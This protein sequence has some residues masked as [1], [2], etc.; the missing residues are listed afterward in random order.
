MD[1]QIVNIFQRLLETNNTA[2]FTAKFTGKNIEVLPFTF[3]IDKFIK[4]NGL[5]DENLKFRRI[6]NTLD[7][8][9]QNLFIEDQDENDDLT[10]ELLKTWLI[11]KFPPPPMK[12]EWLYKMKSIK[13]RKNEDP[14][15]VYDKFQ[16]ILSRVDAAIDLVNTNR[17]RR[18]RVRGITN[19]QIIDA[20]V[21]IFIRN[22]NQSNLDNNGVI[23]AKV[24]SFISKKNPSNIDDWETLFN[25]MQTELIPNCFKTLKEWQFI[26]YPTNI[27]DYDIYK[28]QSRRS[29]NENPNKKVKQESGKKRRRQQTLKAGYKKRK[30]NLYCQKCGRNNHHERECHASH[31][32]FGKLIRGNNPNN[33]SNNANNGR[34]NKG[35]KYCKR[36]RRNNHYTKDCHASFYPDNKPIN[37]NK[38]QKRGYH[39]DNNNNDH[40]DNN[41]NNRNRKEFHTR[42]P[43]GDM[44][45]KDLMALLTQKI[46]NNPNLNA[47]QQF[48]YMATLNN[49][50]NNMS[51]RQDK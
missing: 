6:F 15:L 39:N 10:V 51:A 49:L 45:T 22:N 3:E 43:N 44:S 19:E 42:K 7:V 2:Q 32:V 18:D 28:K 38:F 33:N 9:F 27:S 36:C 21:A 14:K 41:N 40:R 16:T 17:P 20:L 37:D 35:K 26:T 31:D 47:D 13:M 50:S 24:I 34:Q 48:E 11:K 1:G 5:T 25:Q 12:H 23:N 4:I 46:S 29:E 8:H 30:F